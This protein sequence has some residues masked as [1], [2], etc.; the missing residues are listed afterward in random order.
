MSAKYR[1]YFYFPCQ[2]GGDT[3]FGAEWGVRAPPPLPGGNPA[4]SN[5]W[6]P[7]NISLRAEGHEYLLWVGL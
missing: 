2:Q 3:P 6:S 5:T 7:E 4:F 1:R